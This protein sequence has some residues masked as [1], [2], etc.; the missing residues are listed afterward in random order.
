MPKKLNI[1][2]VASEVSPFSKTGG[3]GDVAR[4]LPKALFRLGHKV[5]IITPLYGKIIDKKK[6]KLK[7]IFKDVNL[8]IDQ[9]NSVM[10]NF[11][12]GQLIGGLPVYFVE[13]K[14]HF[15]SL[16]KIYISHRDNIRFLILNVASLK[17][18]NLLEQI[19]DII[20][21]HDW[22]A[23]LIPYF[24]K[25]NYRYTKNLQE[26]KTIFTIHNLAF[27]MSRPWYSV[28]VEKKD[29][30]RKKVPFL[31]DPDLLNINF[32]KRAIL[33]ADFI[34]TVS[35]RY[36]EEIM[37]KKFGQDLHRILKNREDRLLEL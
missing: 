37:T 2:H 17:L 36:R 11:W 23:G 31:N 13:S 15:S 28:P 30:G 35:E 1:I 29:Y 10:V 4:S 16:K 18:I 5:S 26:T 27:Q 9:D 7:L 24:I 32:A 12:Q 25:N 3:L 14:E 6:H 20:H 21:C 34:N 33:S 22:H 8:I 19:P